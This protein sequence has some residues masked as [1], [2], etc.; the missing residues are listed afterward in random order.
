MIHAVDKVSIMR[1]KE[2]KYSEDVVRLS[3]DSVVLIKISVIQYMFG[4]RSMR[5]TIREAEV[6][7]A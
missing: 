6:N 1:R 7:N 2:D 3:I 5:Q 4:L